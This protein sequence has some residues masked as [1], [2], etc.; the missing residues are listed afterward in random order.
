MQN[1]FTNVKAIISHVQANEDRSHAEHGYNEAE[2]ELTQ[3]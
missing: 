2:R 1:F 3:R